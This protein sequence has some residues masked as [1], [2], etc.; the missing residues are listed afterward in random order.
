MHKSGRELD[1]YLWVIFSPLPLGLLPL[2]FIPLPPDFSLGLCTFSNRYLPMGTGAFP[3]GLT[4][5]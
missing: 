2:G 5:D 1:F 4:I 3:L